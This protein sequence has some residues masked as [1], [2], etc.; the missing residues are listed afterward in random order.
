MVMPAV[1]V[2]RMRRQMEGVVMVGNVG[3]A[4]AYFAGRHLEFD[5]PQHGIDRVQT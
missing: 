2:Q 3:V 5:T 4:F 1:G